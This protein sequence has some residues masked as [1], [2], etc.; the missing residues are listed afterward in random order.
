MKDEKSGIG[1]RKD[2][3]SKIPN[4]IKER[5]DRIA[6]GLPRTLTLLGELMAMAK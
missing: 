4:P 2:P 5:R 6:A 1:F 3:K